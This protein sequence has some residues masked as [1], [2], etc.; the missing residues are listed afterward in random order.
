MVEVVHDGAHARRLLAASSPVAAIE[1]TVMPGS[2]GQR[3][4]PD[5]V[6]AGREWRVV[7]IADPQIGHLNAL[8]PDRSN[9][10]SFQRAGSRRFAPA[11]VGAKEQGVLSQTDPPRFPARQTWRHQRDAY[12]DEPGQARG[13]VV[14]HVVQARAAPSESQVLR[15]LVAHHRIHGADDLEQHEP[16]Q[17]REHIPE[18]GA[19]E[20]VGEVLAEAL[21]RGAT[22]RGAVHA[23]RVP[24]DEGAH[25]EARAGHVI[26][27]DGRFDPPH[28]VQQIAEREQRVDNEHVHQPGGTRRDRKRERHDRCE[29][30][31]PQDDE[32]DEEQDSADVAV[33]AGR[34]EA[35]FEPLQRPACEPYGVRWIDRVT[36]DQIDRD[37]DHQGRRLGRERSP[38]LSHQFATSR[39]TPGRR[40]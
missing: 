9:D 15:R 14:H 28:V 20:T 17:A 26:A 3:H 10:A 27:P 35:S 34:T 29:C 4:R 5:H 23:I 2:K 21:D 19:H 25:G 7:R 11:G 32:Q 22:A 13:H 30:R 37:G 33:G 8:E 16:G 18:H 24:A 39:T 6:R 38:E 40:P 1:T 12:D 31:Q 36:Q